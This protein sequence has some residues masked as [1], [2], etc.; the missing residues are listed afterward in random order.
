MYNCVEIEK[1]NRARLVKSMPPL[2][3]EPLRN[4]RHERFCLALS[5]GLSATAAYQ[6]AGYKQTASATANAA[7][8]ITN[9]NIKIRL[10]YLQAMLAKSTEITIESICRELDE[11]NQIAK[12]NGQASAM[13]SA[14]T[15]RAK[16][17]GLLTDK[18]QV[19]AINDPFVGDETVEDIGARMAHDLAKDKGI[20]LTEEQRSEFA[21]LLIEQVQ[22]I[23]EYLA[24]CAAKPV[25]GR[26]WVIE[27]NS[28]ADI[29]DREI[30]HKHRRLT[31]GPR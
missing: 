26:T 30:N 8:L 23:D 15:L 16:L 11:A 12:A 6:R 7:R 25:N 20:E 2:P 24:G 28:P 1:A 10:A 13:V 19:Q 17:A 9:D 22:A 29:R 5:E 31:H 14:S 4:V 27:S 21:A 3:S 18:V